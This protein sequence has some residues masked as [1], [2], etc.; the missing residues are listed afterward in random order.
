MT[1]KRKRGAAAIADHGPTGTAARHLGPAEV[2]AGMVL[3]L[4]SGDAVLGWAKTPQD[5]WWPCLAARAIAPLELFD[6]IDPTDLELPLEPNGDAPRGKVLAYFLGEETCCVVDNGFFDR[7]AWAK[8]PV[9]KHMEEREEY[10]AGTRLA[11]RLQARMDALE[12]GA[13]A[14]AL[15]AAVRAGKATVV[16]AV[17]AAAPAALVAGSQQ[18]DRGGKAAGAGEGPPQLLRSSWPAVEFADWEVRLV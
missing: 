10:A 7:G 15:A 5:P 12:E 11:E 16:E 18:R 6:D 1:G 14:R 9:A 2:E 13:E 8:K 17:P 3:A 4:A